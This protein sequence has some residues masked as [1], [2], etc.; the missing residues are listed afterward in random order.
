M[1][2]FEL[3][4]TMALI[5]AVD[6]MYFHLYRFRLFERPDSVAEEWT[7]LA[8]HLLFLGIVAVMV[9]DP[10]YARAVLVGLFA[11]DVANNGIDVWLERG[12]RAALGGLPSAEYALHVASTLVGGM[13]IGAFLWAP[14]TP[15]TA[16]QEVRGG[17]TLALGAALFAL[18]AGLFARAQLSGTA[19][20]RTTP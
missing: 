16:T 6:V 5:G 10:P 2:P 15:L 20:R 13:A 18:E 12:S 9:A 3:M 7:H 1:I 4:M 14:P 17:I 19:P 8:R 11:V